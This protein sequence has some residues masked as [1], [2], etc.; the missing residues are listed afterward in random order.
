[1]KLSNAA[2]NLFFKGFKMYVYVLCV[3][4]SET[5]PNTHNLSWATNQPG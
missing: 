3:L 4:K 5:L 1:M 2:T